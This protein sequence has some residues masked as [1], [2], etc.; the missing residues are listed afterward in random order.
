[1]SEPLTD[2]EL[3]AIENRAQASTLHLVSTRPEQWDL[4]TLAWLQRPEGKADCQLIRH[5]KNDIEDLVAEV[6]RLRLQVA[7]HA[8]RIAKQSELLSRRAEKSQP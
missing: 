2:A 5:A 6:R 7:G 1:M 8:E 3:A 4:V